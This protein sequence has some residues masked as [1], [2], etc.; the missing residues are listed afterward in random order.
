MPTLTPISRRTGRARRLAVSVADTTASGPIPDT[1]QGLDLSLEALEADFAT[2]AASAGAGRERGGDRWS[3]PASAAV[4]VIVRE[5]M[6]HG[7]F[8]AVHFT[9]ATRRGD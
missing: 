4:L 2:L 9:P 1:R 8:E 6:H 5:V 7:R 3:A